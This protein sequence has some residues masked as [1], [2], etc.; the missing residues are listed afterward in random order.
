VGNLN[1]TVIGNRWLKG[2]YWLLEARVENC[3]EAPQP[4]RFLMIKVPRG[5]ST[6][7]LLRRPFGIH[8]FS[9]EG[10]RGGRIKILYKV[11]GRGTTLMTGFGPDDPIDILGP[12]GRGFTT[13]FPQSTEH[14]GASRPEA[15]PVPVIVAGGIGGAPL[16]YLA[17]V[18]VAG[19]RRPLV[20]AGGNTADDVLG[21]EE[22][23]KLGLEVRRATMD[24]S[25]G[26][27]GNVIDCL[28][29]GPLPEGKVAFYACG[30]W[31]MLSALARFSRERGYAMQ[32]TVDA[33]MACG[34][35]LCLGC[36]TRAA[37]THPEA[38]LMVCKD[39]PVFDLEELS[40]E[41]PT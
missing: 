38:Y 29:G 16:L 8:D 12:L 33:P 24:G 21:V 23:E 17:R 4:G 34:L 36:A 20:Y 15:T 28:L 22:F 32:A 37:E 26:Y 30:P 39:G 7:P 27:G 6:D 40:W 18:M 1:G 5:S 31:P 10:E 35:G 25:C 9:R 19:G 2:S 41:R 11:C 14:V 3:P 13:D